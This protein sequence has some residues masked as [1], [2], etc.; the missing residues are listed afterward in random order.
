[1]KDK[2]HGLDCWYST[3]Y[4]PNERVFSQRNPR[5]R[6]RSIEK[7][8]FSAFIQAIGFNLKRL[9]ILHYVSDTCLIIVDG[10]PEIQVY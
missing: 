3:I 2:N 9:K 1:M 7:N 8:Q 6:Y 5:I 4:V 10:T